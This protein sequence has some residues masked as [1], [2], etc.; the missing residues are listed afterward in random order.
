MFK[1][2]NGNTEEII[3]EFSE[4]EDAVNYMDELNK[5][6]NRV[7]VA[8]SWHLKQER[9]LYKDTDGNVSYGTFVIISN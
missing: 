4:Y 7:R 1:V 6:F 3:T 2:L 5:H 8:R 9:G